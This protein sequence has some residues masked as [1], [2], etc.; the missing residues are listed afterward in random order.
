MHD[1][2]PSC[3][4][5]LGDTSR[6]PRTL[7]EGSSRRVAR[8]LAASIEAQQKEAQASSFVTCKAFTDAYVKALE[9]NDFKWASHSTV[10][11][12]FHKNAKLIT[13]DKQSFLGLAAVIR[14]LN[15]GT[16]ESTSEFTVEYSDAHP[17]SSLYFRER[18][19]CL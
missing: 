18:V 15:T 14:R 10:S 7:L 9:T 19:L 3:G 13:Q 8:E 5:V 4:L 16:A 6:P 12:L 11:S 17:T 2:F 1:S